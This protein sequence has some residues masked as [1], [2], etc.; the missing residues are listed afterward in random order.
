M[1]GKRRQDYQ[2][3]AHIAF[4]WGE[5]FD[6]KVA[7]GNIAR[8]ALGTD[9]VPMNSDKAWSI[10][11]A[12]SKGSE[13]KSV[14]AK[15]TADVAD[16]LKAN[17][18]A[19]VTDL[20]PHLTVRNFRQLCAAHEDEVKNYCIFFVDMRDDDVVRL[21]KEVAK[22]KNAYAQEL[23]DLKENADDGADVTEENFRLQP[24]RIR[25]SSSHFPWVP[26][27]PDFSK[28]TNG[29][30][31]YTGR[32]SMFVLEWDTRRYAP[33]KGKSLMEVFQSIAYEDVQFQELPDEAPNLM[34][35]LPDPES[36]LS[37]ELRRGLTG[38]VGAALALL[39][40]AGAVALFPEL[41]APV[42][43]LAVTIFFAM[44]LFC[45]PAACRRVLGKFL[46]MH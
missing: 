34:T 38:F 41:P 24:V 12:G 44:V 9:L 6:V 2:A 15:D 10:L 30:W 3:A 13:L 33:L 31:D 40:L 43:C 42:A 23:A 4:S 8:E 22:S 16:L 25:T 28:F 45:W 32:S 11:V 5:F 18:E 39:F 1:R 27:C 29:L 17:L 36:S 14:E 19:S 35:I 26:D 37:G 20:A 7:D 21:T 46:M